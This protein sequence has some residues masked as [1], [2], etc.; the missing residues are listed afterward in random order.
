MG[1]GDFICLVGEEV[2]FRVLGY[3]IEWVSACDTAAHPSIHKSSPEQKSTYSRQV[4]FF[5]QKKLLK[6]LLQAD[7]NSTSQVVNNNYNGR[8]GIQARSY[9][10]LLCPVTILV[11]VLA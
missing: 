9:F 10:S 11:R 7:A 8:S 4:L 2:S 3:C 6:R 5:G 1:V